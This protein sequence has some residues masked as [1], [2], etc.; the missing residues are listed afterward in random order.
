MFAMSMRVLPDAIGSKSKCW[1]VLP[2]LLVQPSIFGWV[3]FQ[4]SLILRR[5]PLE[6]LLSHLNPWK[7]VDLVC[8][9][10]YSA[11]ALTGCLQLARY[12]QGWQTRRWSYCTSCKA[13][14]SFPNQKV[15]CV[16][17]LELAVV[18]FQVVQFLLSMAVSPPNVHL[19]CV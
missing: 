6:V 11:V 2:E 10:I 17:V 3:M 16:V 14:G 1:R 5:K 12:G 8:R 4:M 9:N 7:H 15:S 19:A 13:Q 18:S